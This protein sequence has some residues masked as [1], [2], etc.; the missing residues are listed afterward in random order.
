MRVV[1]AVCLAICCVCS[2]CFR[3]AVWFLLAID[4]CL[5]QLLCQTTIH[6][7]DDALVASAV[8]PS[9]TRVSGT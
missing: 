4:L 1:V 2:V 3:V 9:V 7:K 8:M 5:C 6:A